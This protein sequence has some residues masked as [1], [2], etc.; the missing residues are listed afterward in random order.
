MALVG[1]ALVSASGV[2][3]GQTSQRIENPKAKQKIVPTTAPL[4]V[5]HIIDH[6]RR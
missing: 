6:H 1:T 2:S 5:V 3:L 4:L